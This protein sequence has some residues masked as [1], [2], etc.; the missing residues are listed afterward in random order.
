MFKCCECGA[1]YNIK[2]DYCDCGNDTF[3]E[4][5]TQKQSK[6]S[7]LKKYDIS[8]YS[9]LFFISCLILSLVIL[10]FVGNPKEQNPNTKIV[11]QKH[12]KKNIPS[13]NSFWDDTPVK[14]LEETI[15]TDTENTKNILPTP[16]SDYKTILPKSNNTSKSSV[17]PIVKP[18]PVK[19]T[20]QT[21]K[22]N[23]TTTTKTTKINNTEV[24]NYKI[25]LRNALF[26]KLDCIQIKGCGKCGIQFSV[27]NEGKLI[28]RAFSFQSDN[29]TLNNE[30]YKMMMR[31]P[32]Y[33]PPPNSYKG[34]LIKITIEFNNGEYEIKLI[35]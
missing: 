22:S 31:L 29:D 8:I 9:I 11:Q 6:P 27:N 23:Q 1:E 30:V 33:N 13:I 19:S 20:T 5:I 10:L 15:I 3:N 34:E 12:I 21:N 35:K 14:K 32:K 17:K 16:P 26:S 18:T 28:N 2:P 25:K 7:L 4:I 24:L